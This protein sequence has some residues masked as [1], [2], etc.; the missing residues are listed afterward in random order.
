MQ[1][2]VCPGSGQLPHADDGSYLFTM[3]ANSVIFDNSKVMC[4]T[5]IPPIRFTSFR[6]GAARAIDYMLA[7]PEQQQEDPAFDAFCDRAEQ[8]M[9]AAKET[10]LK[11]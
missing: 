11:E 7:H 1:Y 3:A 8:A 6:E 10:L 9:E 2:A 4:A 5:G